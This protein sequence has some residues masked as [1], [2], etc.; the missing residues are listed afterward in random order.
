[1]E[2]KSTALI[3]EIP[4]APSSVDLSLVNT[5]SDFVILNHLNR[6]L[7]K[8]NKFAKLEG[9]LVDRW[10]IEDD[11]K[12]YIFHLAPNS[13]FSD[14]SPI[15]GIDVL[16]SIQ[17][18]MKL[19]TANH[20]NFSAIKSVRLIDP[21]T[22]EIVLKHRNTQFIR[23][24]TYP[25]FGVLHKSQRDARV[26]SADYRISS[27]PYSL[28][29]Q[30]D[31]HFL[32][33]KNPF[34]PFQ[35]Q[36]PPESIEFQTGNLGDLPNRLIREEVDVSLANIP[37]RSEYKLVEDARNLKIFH[38][39]MG[40]TFWVTINPLSKKLKS[41]AL[42]NYIQLI[43]RSEGFNFEDKAP[44][45]SKANQLYLPDGSGRPGEE[46]LKSV[47]SRIIKNA[48][49][50]SSREKL[51]LLLGSRFPFAE[52]VISK[53]EKSFVLEVKHFTTKEEWE[54]CVKSKSFDL[55]ILN[56][57]F[58]SED[59]H[60]N[61]QTTFNPLFSLVITDPLIGQFQKQLKKALDTDSEEK[62]HK[63]YEDIGVTV[64]EKGYVAPIAH[65]NSVYIHNNKWDF[66]NISTLYPDFALW[67]ISL[68]K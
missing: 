10:L 35:V 19:N 39:H 32:L 56:N 5:V 46:R 30:K 34:F 66:S 52:E 1:M 12:R 11:F 15:E 48:K 36:S 17:R 3:A 50:L 54:K 53:L 13:R 65:R 16:E 25:E 51:S 67:K 49:L 7:V 37:T 2:S 47:W 57:D 59:L 8:L 21:N 40:Y 43:L 24:V 27:G 68:K 9:D 31:R 61:L 55:Y 60:E 22:V 6:P 20:F 63:I 28:M 4:S 18:Q 58:S 44:V 62:R 42:R 41:V 29:T 38:P 26:G 33:K 14:G 45:W 23:H 64:L